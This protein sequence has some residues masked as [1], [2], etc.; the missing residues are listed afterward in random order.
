MTTFSF[1]YLHNNTMMGH[2]ESSNRKQKKQQQLLYMIGL[3]QRQFQLEIDKQVHLVSFKTSTGNVLDA[4]VV[5]FLKILHLWP[6][7][8]AKLKLV[9][10]NLMKKSR[11]R[12]R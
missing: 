6:S 1:G 11:R 12:R 3:Q 2:L 10:T 8:Q 9:Q 4:F 7:M 5:A